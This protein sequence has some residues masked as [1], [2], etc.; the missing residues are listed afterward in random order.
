VPGWTWDTEKARANL[1]K[2]GVPFA[3]A[4]VVLE[5]PLALTVPDRTRTEERLVTI[6][7]DA[8]GVLLVVAWISY[9][10]GGRILSARKAT[11]RERRSYAEEP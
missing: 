11:P 5:D 1:R 3:E 9:E 8:E 6:G 2:H 7:R 10:S 4:L